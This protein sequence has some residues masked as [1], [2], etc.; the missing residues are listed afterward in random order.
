MQPQLNFQAIVNTI[1]F[2]MSPQQSVEAPAWISFPGASPPHTGKSFILRLDNRFED[3]TVKDLEQWGHVI[4][5]GGIGGS[6]KMIMKDPDSG[7]LLG[8]SQDSVLWY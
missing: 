3:E 1:D 4:E 2:G 6:R 7:M 8:G 5:R